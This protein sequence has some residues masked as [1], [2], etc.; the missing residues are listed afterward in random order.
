MR[1][2]VGARQPAVVAG[3]RQQQYAG[4]RGMQ[5]RTAPEAE[6]QQPERRGYDRG[7]RHHHTGKTRD[8][9]EA[10][11]RELEPPVE[12]DPLGVGRRIRKRI[13]SRDLAVLEDP[14]ARRQM[15]PRVG[16]RDPPESQAC[17]R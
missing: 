5:S 14:L 11:Q 7:A 13:R 1:H 6:Q 17:R 16:A 8:P 9:L 12:V 2:H 3:D 4:R 15:P 10:A